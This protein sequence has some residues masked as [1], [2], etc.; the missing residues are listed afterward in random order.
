MYVVTLRL[1]DAAGNTTRQ[2]FRVNVP[3]A[4]NTGAALD[5]PAQMLTSRCQ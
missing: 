5:G 2:D 1:T 4:S 3:V